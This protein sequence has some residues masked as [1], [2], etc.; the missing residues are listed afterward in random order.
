VALN[1]DWAVYTTES[2]AS[3]AKVDCDYQ[4]FPIPDDLKW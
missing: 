4:D 1:P 2:Q 3:D